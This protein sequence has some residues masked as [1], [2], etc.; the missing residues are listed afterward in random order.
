[1]M[2]ERE[3]GGLV[4]TR[5]QEAIH[6]FWA[7]RLRAS[8]KQVRPG[9]SGNRRMRAGARRQFAV[10]TATANFQVKAGAETAAAWVKRSVPGRRFLVGMSSRDYSVARESP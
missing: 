3:P 9:R 10:I 4:L 5:P 1:Q 6:D 2:M 7:M 8:A